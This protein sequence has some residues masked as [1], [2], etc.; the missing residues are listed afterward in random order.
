MNAI[1]AWIRRVLRGP[2]ASAW[3]GKLG[4][5]AARFWLLMDLFDLLSE[6][7]EMLDQL[8]REGVALRFVALL[9]AG[10]TGLASVFLVLGQPSVGTYLS[11]F[12]FVS[13]FLLTAILLPETGNSLVNPVEGLI[14]AHQPINGATYT[15]AKLMHLARIVL[16]LAPAINAV[17][18]VAGLMLKGAGWSY[19]FLHLLAAIGVG[20]VSAL[21]CCALY[22]WLMRLVPA[23]RLKA[24]GQ[25]AGALPF[26]GMIAMGPIRRAFAAI[27]VVMPPQ[28]AL[29]WGLSIALG[30]GAVA[31][32]VLGL[33][34]LSADYLIRVSSI[35]HGHRGK[36][37]RSRKS[38]IGGMVGSVF[39][40]PPARAGFAYVSQMARR[41]FQFRRQ[42]L[43]MLII[44]GFGWIP[45]IASGW[46]TDPFSGQFTVAHLL[47]HV[48][49][50]LLLLICSL[51]A[52][53]G[54]YKGAW[55]FQL[56]PAQAFRGFARGVY[57]ALWIP[58]VVIPHLILL[59]V[60]TWSWGMWHSGL[61]A[62]YSAAV[63]SV[64]LA[65]ELR[66]IDA[67]PFSKQVDPK[68]GAVMLPIMMLGGVAAAAVVGVQYY[69]VFRTPMIAG[70]AA[71]AV[72]VAAY[73][74]TRSSWG[75]LEASI[76]YGLA[77][78]S[79]ESGGL[80]QEIEL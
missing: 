54:D 75:A 15:A 68:R 19:P 78:V 27:H 30:A 2:W 50:L 45:L 25:I 3:L 33:R 79:M 9:Y 12:L 76:R 38:W 8:G 51:L 74:L 29:R 55:L 66:L 49:G 24:A 34:A 22:G 67:V 16:Y 59:L 7:G 39:G 48:F 35:V 53:G 5:D 28:P 60:F 64:Y 4:I 52:Y 80:Y 1:R 43:P 37:A 62:A 36:P 42:A 11:T 17:P 40:G 47:P 41:D 10:M 23:A 56:V 69:F 71:A 18:A 57:A 77:T 14:L 70:T 21:F 72:A 63:C 26:F 6:R 73:F 32:V 65:L 13:A 46:R 44:G 20:A 61:F 58:V 31:I